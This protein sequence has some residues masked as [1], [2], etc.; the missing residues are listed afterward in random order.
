AAPGRVRSRVAP[1][2]PPPPVNVKRY[3]AGGYSFAY[4]SGWRVGQ[5]DRPVTSYRETVLNSADG[6]AKVTID[7]SPGESTEP[8]AKA[9]QVQAPTS[10]TRGYRQLSFRP[11]SI[12]GHPAFVWEFEVAGADPRRVDLFLRTRSGGFAI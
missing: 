6:A 2:R 3:R 1:S 9:A 4:P 10:I 8:A 5:S 11:T 7:Y 12:R